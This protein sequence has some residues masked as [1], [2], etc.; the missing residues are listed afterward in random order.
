M[1]V[2]LASL[3]RVCRTCRREIAPGE[4]GA[5]AA[6]QGAETR[7]VERLQLALPGQGQRRTAEQGQ[8]GAS[9]ASAQKLAGDSLVG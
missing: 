2:G 1:T 9:A 3:G 4:G 5:T 6:G 7:G 8:H